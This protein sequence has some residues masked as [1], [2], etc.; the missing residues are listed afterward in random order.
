MAAQR[1]EGKLLVQAYA[2]PEHKAAVAA[3]L[4]KRT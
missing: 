1:R 3:F 2:T 4:D